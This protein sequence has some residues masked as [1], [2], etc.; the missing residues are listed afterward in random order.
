MVTP[1]K[2]ATTNF[3]YFPSIGRLLDIFILKITQQT[4]MDITYFL[5]FTYF[6]SHWCCSQNV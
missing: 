5:F 3:N 2:E 1:P 4:A 6:S